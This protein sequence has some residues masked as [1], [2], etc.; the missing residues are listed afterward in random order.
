MDLPSGVKNRRLTLISSMAGLEGF[1]EVAIEIP[2]PTKGGNVVA[3][4]N[5]SAGAVG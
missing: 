4:R 1:D 5:E 2:M 3:E